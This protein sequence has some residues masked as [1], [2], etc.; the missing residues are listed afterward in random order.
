MLRWN[1]ASLTTNLAQFLIKSRVAHSKSFTRLLLQKSTYEFMSLG[2][3]LKGP[4]SFD[5][6]IDLE[7]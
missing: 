5:R 7:R 4:E 3:D 6:E 2:T 1:Y